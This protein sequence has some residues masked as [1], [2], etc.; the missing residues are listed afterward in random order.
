M[1]FLKHAID[2]TGKF[3]GYNEVKK[4]QWK[5]IA[6]VVSDHMIS[7][8]AYR[9]GLGSMLNPQSAYVTKPSIVSE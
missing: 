8:L 2:K 6:E 5:G 3:L 1:I 4:L 9:Q 7:L